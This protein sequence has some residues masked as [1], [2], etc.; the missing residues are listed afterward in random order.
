MDGLGFLDS[1][2]ALEECLTPL[3]GE[4]LVIGHHPEHQAE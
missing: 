2:C 3:A 1:A 4:V